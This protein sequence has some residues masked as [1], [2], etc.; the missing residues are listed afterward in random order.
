MPAI[1]M[2]TAETITDAQIHELQAELRADLA[3]LAD[4]PRFWTSHLRKAITE[5]EWA[6]AIGDP[7]RTHLARTRCAEILN[8]RSA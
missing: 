4:D 7:F 5:T 3:A 2:I 1:S 8:E 6:L